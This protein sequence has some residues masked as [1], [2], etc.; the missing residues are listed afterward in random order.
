VVEHFP[1]IFKAI[2][3]IPSTAKKKKL[4]NRERIL[5]VARE[6]HQVTYKSKPIRTTADFSAKTLK[7]RRE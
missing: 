3:L 5:K 2:G 1:S 4:Q 6:K 7:A